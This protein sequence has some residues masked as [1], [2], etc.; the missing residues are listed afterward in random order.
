VS[1]EDATLVWEKAQRYDWP[2]TVEGGVPVTRTRPARALLGFLAWCEDDFRAGALRHLLQSGDM[3][4]D[5]DDGPPP[6]QA[7]R[8]LARVPCAAAERG[9]Q[10]LVDATAVPAGLDD[11]EILALLEMAHRGSPR[12][13]ARRNPEQRQPEGNG[14]SL[15]EL[16]ETDDR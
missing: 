14:P 2:V 16:S 10:V 5:L 13:A 3:R 12:R 9:D 4:L 6:G 1:G 7:A 11:L 8:L 15:D